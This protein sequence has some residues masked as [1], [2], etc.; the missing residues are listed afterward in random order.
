[1]IH[2]RQQGVA[3]LCFVPVPGHENS[4]GIWI[5]LTK[6]IVFRGIMGTGERLSGHI[7]FAASLPV[8]RVISL[9]WS[10]DQG[11]VITTGET[12]SL[13]STMRRHHQWSAAACTECKHGKLAAH[14]DHS[15]AHNNNNCLTS[16]SQS[17]HQST[18]LH[19]AWAWGPRH[20][21]SNLVLTRAPE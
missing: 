1:M 15:G 7:T 4:N 9:K 10:A 19:P 14:S 8:S 20:S 17:S 2:T 12:S 6:A 3:N 16:E 11:R 5:S 13:V 21:K 18:P